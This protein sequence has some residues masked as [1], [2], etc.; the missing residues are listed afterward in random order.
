MVSRADRSQLSQWWW[1]VDKTLLFSAIALMAGGLVLS[2]AASPA[3]AE[4]L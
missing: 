3:I 2:L 4:K 1:T